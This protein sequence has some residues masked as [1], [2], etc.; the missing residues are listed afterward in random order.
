MRMNQIRIPLVVGAKYGKL[1]VIGDGPRCGGSRTWMC[2]CECGNE[3]PIKVKSLNSGA[4]KACGCMRGERHG[5]PPGYSS[6]ANMLTRCYN[7]KGTEYENYG[8]RGITV[9]DRWRKSFSAFIQ[10]MGPRPEGA[11]IERKNNNGNY[12]PDNCV[13]ANRHEQAH[14]KRNNYNITLSGVT[15]TKEEWCRHFGVTRQTINRRVN[16]GVPDEKLFEGLNR[17]I[18]L[19]TI[20]GVTKPIVE[21]ARQNGMDSHT[22]RNRV[23]NKW[24]EHLLLIPGSLNRVPRKL[25]DLIAA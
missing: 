22:L 10:D 23:K 18:A 7:P 4:A 3:K 1:T 21:W 13:W 9:C 5:R 15:K 12:E 17:P 11:S 24:P 20:G 6:W 25:A 8:G 16:R 19:L 14:N 2:R